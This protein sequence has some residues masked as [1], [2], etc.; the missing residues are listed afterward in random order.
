MAFH[1]P[2]SRD[3]RY[4]SIRWSFTADTTCSIDGLSSRVRAGPNLAL[5]NGA[6]FEGRGFGA[7][8]ASAGEVVFNTAMGGYQEALTDPSYT[9]QIL[10]MTAPEIGN[11]GVNPEDSRESDAIAVAGFVVRDHSRE[12]G[13]THRADRAS[14]SLA[15]ESSRHPR[16]RGPRHPGDRPDA[17]GRGGDAR[18]PRIRRERLGSGAS[19]PSTWG[20]IP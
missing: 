14:P 15:G 8:A 11:Y 13:R 6:V 10:V 7:A 1:W 12:S 19:D 2:N 9:G 3:G 4:T 17:A 18:R 5:E 16:P 20:S